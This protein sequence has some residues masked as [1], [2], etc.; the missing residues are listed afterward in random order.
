MTRNEV[1][2]TLATKI[3]EISEINLIDTPIDQNRSS[4]WSKSICCEK[5]KERETLVNVFG[6][7]QDEVLEN[8]F[9]AA[10]SGDGNEKSRILT[11]H[12]SS[13]L[14]FLCFSCIKM[15]PITIL[16]TEY[17]DVMFEVK[18]DVINPSLGKPSNIDILLL[19]SD[20]SKILFL[21]SKFTEYIS[22]GRVFLSK[23]Y[24]KFYNTLCQDKN[25]FDFE[26][27]EIEVRHKPNKESP[28]SHISNEYCL[29]N[30]ERPASYLGGIKQAFS[31][32]IGIATGPAEV[33]TS[34]NKAYTK[35]TLE[36]AEE[37]TFASI[38][39]NC[40]QQKYNAYSKLYESTFG[41]KNAMVIKKAIKKVVPESKT[42]DKL[43]IHDSLLTYQEI[44]NGF[45]LPEKIR[46][47]YSL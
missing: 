45:E 12:S 10:T 47:F 21:E 39:F 27:S 14:A 17:V 18:N 33:Q 29:H 5:G 35:Q 36:N 11:L 3:R 40:N 24:I 31:H 23:R 28:K 9:D 38:V 8:L 41:E 2:E 20:R 25:R 34:A 6:L 32:L 37:I 22:G 16:G 30:D 42:L 13:L 7:T 46:T 43:I 4:N 1:A 26:A 15:H 19:N 44:F